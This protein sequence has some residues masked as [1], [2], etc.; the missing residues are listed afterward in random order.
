LAGKDI[1]EKRWG[2]IM[3]WSFVGAMAGLPW[4]ILAIV[5]A[6]QNYK[7]KKKELELK[8]LEMEVEKQNGKIKLLEE[9]NKKYDSII[10]DNE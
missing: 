2:I 4:A 8:A 10:K 3:N 1:F 9:E 7:I 6:S 5:K